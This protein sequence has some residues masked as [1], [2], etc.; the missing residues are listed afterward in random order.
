[1]KNLNQPNQG[2]RQ[3]SRLLVFCLVLLAAG[4]IGDVRAEGIPEPGVIF[5]GVVRNMSNGGDVR[6]TSGSLTWT[7]KPSTG[8]SPIVAFGHLQNIND[9]FSYVLQ[10]PCETRIPGFAS[11]SN[12]LSLGTSPVTYQCSQ[13]TVEGEPASF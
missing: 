5:Y 3:G 13:V 4:C 7:F 9:Q 10:V 2:K 11:S 1:M 12:A 8:G 6:L